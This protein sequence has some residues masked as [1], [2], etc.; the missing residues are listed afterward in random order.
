[1]RRPVRQHRWAWW[2][3]SLCS[4]E[5]RK[6]N[7][8]RSLSAQRRKSILPMGV[9]PRPYVR[10]VKQCSECGRSFKPSSRH[11]RCPACRAKTMCACGRTMQA[12]SVQCVSC[13][14]TSNEANGNWKGGR[15]RHKA[16]YVMV[17]CPD[18][19]ARRSRHRSSSTSWWPS[20]F[21]GDTSS[22]ENPCITETASVRTIVPKTSSS[23][24]N[25]NRLVFASVTRS[26]GRS[27][28]SIGMWAR[29]VAHLQQCSL[30]RK[31]SWRWRESNPR[32]P[33]CQWG[34]SER[35]R[36]KI[37]GHHRS[38]AAVGDPSLSEVSHRVLRRSPVVSRSQWRPGSDRAAGSGGTR[39]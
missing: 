36:E 23:G 9:A 7:W 17:A 24:R 31:H 22:P 19:L 32:L 1:M 33:G 4:S 21:S 16:G 35:I 6:T 15:T 34:F 8:S 10:T 37:S 38:P 14:T 25:R 20:S 5:V 39:V 11:R 3:R 28:S 30:V 18:T 27:R 12:K 13:R 29:D 2:K 26:L